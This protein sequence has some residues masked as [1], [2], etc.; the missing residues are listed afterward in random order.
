MNMKKVWSLILVAAMV[1][2]FLPGG[3]VPVH[4]VAAEN[5]YEEG[6]TWAFDQNVLLGKIKGLVSGN[7]AGTIQ[8]M[9]HEGNGSALTPSRAIADGVLTTEVVKNW[10]N[11]VGHGVFY[12]L[13]AVLEAGRIYQLSIN[14][15]GGNAAAAMNGMTVSFGNYTDTLNGDGG[16]IQEWQDGNMSAMHNADTKLARTV[17]G[18]LST[19]ASNTVVIEFAATDAMAA[20]GWMLITFPLALNGSYK[21]GCVSVDEVKSVDGYTWKFDKTVETFGKTNEFKTLYYGNEANTVG[22]VNHEG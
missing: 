21:L 12:K 11:T 22:I 8:V 17:S 2:S 15:Y 16:N 10:G 13:P 18:N 7:A 4:A 3:I 5:V 1:L 9:N 14:L 19:D 6:Y 20:S